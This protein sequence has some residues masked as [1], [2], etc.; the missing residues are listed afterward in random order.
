MNEQSAF[1]PPTVTIDCA[2]N[3]GVRRTPWCVASLSGSP[4]TAIST[5]SPKR[6]AAISHSPS[7]SSPA[8][9]SSSGRSVVVVVVVPRPPDGQS[10]V[11]FV[12][13]GAILRYDDAT[14][15]GSFD[16]R[17]A[18]QRRAALGR[19]ST[20]AGREESACAP[21][22]R[23]LHSAPRPQH[24]HSTPT[25]RAQHTRTTHLEQVVARLALEREP[26][27]ME[28]QLPIRVV[29]KEALPADLVA[30]VQPRRIDREERANARPQLER[31]VIPRRAA[32]RRDAAIA[33]GA[34]RDMPLSGGETR[35]AMSAAE[36]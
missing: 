13:T 12:A 1:V 10:R 27:V 33:R 21:T 18:R 35:R 28:A 15:I 24:I 34:R 32:R 9:E 4:L 19:R 30:V 26:P 29:A 5:S 16:S 14:V 20:E 17:S 2:E 23:C 31:A 11:P 7:R 8:R 6:Y 25:T 3:L 22:P 36:R